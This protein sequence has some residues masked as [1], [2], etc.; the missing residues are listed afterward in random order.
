MKSRLPRGALECL[1]TTPSP[2]LLHLQSVGRT[3]A[4]KG[5]FTAKQYCFIMSVITI[6]LAF[7]CYKNPYLS[8]FNLNCG[9]HLLM[10]SL[11]AID[12]AKRRAA[13]RGSKPRRSLSPLLALKWSKESLT[14]NESERWEE[15]MMSEMQNSFTL[16]HCL[17]RSEREAE[18]NLN[19]RGSFSSWLWLGT[20]QR[21]GKGGGQRAWGSVHERG[22]KKGWLSE[23]VLRDGGA[24]SQHMFGHC[25]DNNACTPK[26]IMMKFM[27][28]TSLNFPAALFVR[29]HSRARSIVHDTIKT[30]AYSMH[31]SS[32][33]ASQ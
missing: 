26:A 32:L 6:A 31:L 23:E 30:P 29:W 13:L 18:R 9:F 15:W 5:F 16:K 3:K 8:L 4:L 14:S 12:L 7:G 2:L 21:L 19:E 27:S 22:G 24:G 28:C 20:S 1:N 17:R 10:S 25:F 33:T 11:A